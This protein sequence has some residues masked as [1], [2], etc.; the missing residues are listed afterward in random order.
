METPDP[1][2]AYVRRCTELALRALKSFGWENCVEPMSAKEFAI[3]HPNPVMRRKYLAAAQDL[4]D[5]PLDFD[6]DGK[7]E[8]FTK[9]ERMP[10]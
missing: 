6:K 5:R 9:N 2:P 8:G 4:R 3:S 7:V 10:E 1:D